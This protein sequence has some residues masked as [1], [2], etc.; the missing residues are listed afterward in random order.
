MN[1]KEKFRKGI[2]LRLGVMIASTIL[3]IILL[4]LFAQKFFQERFV[5]YND[6]VVLRYAI[7]VL[8]EGYIG[9]KIYRYIRYLCDIEYAD[10]F[11]LRKND[12]RL[13]FIRLKTNALVIKI[14]I[15]VC[16]I[17]LI[18]TGFINAVI[19]YT[20]L[21]FLLSILII[22]TSVFIFYSKKY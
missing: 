13:N 4:V 20:I 9:T 17:A 3:P 11:Y 21:S 1:N 7:F 2:M 8:L 19:F 16:G 6:L 22:Y 5:V 15:Y 14:L 12:E 18:T 10:L